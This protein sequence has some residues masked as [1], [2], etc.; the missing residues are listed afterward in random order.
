MVEVDSPMVLVNAKRK[1]DFEDPPCKVPKFGNAI[2]LIDILCSAKDTSLWTQEQKSRV[3]FHS[4]WRGNEATMAT[5]KIYLAIRSLYH[6]D[7]IKSFMMSTLVQYNQDF[8]TVSKFSLLSLLFR[9][10]N[11]FDTEGNILVRR[12]IAMNRLSDIHSDMFKLGLVHDATVPL[13][14]TKD[15]KLHTFIFGE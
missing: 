13:N 7:D 9:D 14:N 5:V 12:Q 8:C 15:L 11:V 1:L 6:G 4:L 2:D 10:I 3:I